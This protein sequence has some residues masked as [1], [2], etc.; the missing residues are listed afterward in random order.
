MNLGKVALVT[1]A[2]AGIGAATASC[3]ASDGFTVYGVARRSELLNGLAGVRPIQADITNDAQRQDCVNR[4]LNDAGR[5]DILV[6]NAGSGLYGAIEDTPL[7]NAR[8]LFE[9]NVFAHARLIQLFLPTFRK[10]GTGTIVNVSSIAGRIYAPFGGWYHASKVAL[11]SL[12]D[13]LRIELKPYGVRVILIEPGAIDTEG[14][15]EVSESLRSI[16]G[17]T[18]YA[19]RADALACSL[20]ELES[21][22]AL[23]VAKTISLVVSRRRPR[24]R[25]IVGKGAKAAVL[26]YQ[27]LPDRLLDRLLEARLRRKMEQIPGC[28]DGVGP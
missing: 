2:S 28:M 14:L 12:S 21:V 15:R 13:S 23:S 6:N 25:Y 8:N 19:D 16:S 7:E 24:T 10:Q 27:L 9:I 4:V 18:C 3:L 11:E 26:M 1:G 17:S 20:A 22:P 5:I